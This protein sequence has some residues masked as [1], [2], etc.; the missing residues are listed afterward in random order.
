LPHVA[1]PRGE[2]RELAV[3]ALPRAADVRELA[4]VVDVR[5]VGDVRPLAR[6]PAAA[7]PRARAPDPPSRDLRVEEVGVLERPSEPLRT[8]NEPC[9]TRFEV[10]LVD[11]PVRIVRNLVGRPRDGAP[12]VR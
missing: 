8:L 3:D 6:A 5:A 12:E 11:G 10:G 1:P 2:E 9:V 4:T 7:D